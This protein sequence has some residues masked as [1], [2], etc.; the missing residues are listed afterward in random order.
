MSYSIDYN[1]LDPGLYVKHQGPPHELFDLWREQDPV[2]WNPP[3]PDYQ[4]PMPNRSMSKGF[5]VLT[6]H[7]D[8]FDVSRNQ[9]LFTSHDEG[10]VI[11]DNHGPELE[12]L[13]AN[14]MGMRPPEHAAVKQVI[15]PPFSPKAM[16]EMAP[17][18]E[19]L[20]AEIID[21]VCERGECEFVFDVAAKLPVFTFCELMGIPVEYR[22]RVVELGNAIAD[23]ETRKDLSADPVVELAEIA[24]ELGEQ[25]RKHPDDRLLSQIV[26]SNE[27]N[28]EPLQVAMF[29]QVFAI[30]GHE[31]TRSTASHFI[32]LMNRHPD[33]YELLLEDVDGRIDNAIEE[34]LRYT[35]TTTNFRRTTTAATEIGGVPVEKGAKIYL[36]Y[37][38]ANRD[39]AVFEN[40]H[41]FDI[42]RSNARKHL[43]FG[44]GP[45]VC[46]GA[47]LARLQL[48][49]LL[50]QIVTRI[51]DIRVVE[52]QWLRSI[53]FN[54]IIH[55]PVEFTPASATGESL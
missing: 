7:Q 54:A 26:N 22:E 20:A 29:F 42:T 27:L 5:Y 50:K 30:A 23:V 36:S 40:P 24:I 15:T 48:K 46:T 13:Q 38:G 3:T 17:K 1:I 45:H 37:A 32:N 34:V 14:F 19:A 53:W 2:H 52:A 18:I 12:Q 9:E 21:D 6:R 11:W 47:R 31:T 10:F 51:P 41:Q 8:V 28:L 25:K 16:L 4:S 43:A 33:Q 44:T 55:M 39:P 49:A 35:S